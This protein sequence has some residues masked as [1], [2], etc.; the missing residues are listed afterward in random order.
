MMDEWNESLRCPAC[1][2][3]GI[4]RLCQDEDAETPTVR[5]V[6]SGFKIVA[7]EYGPD[8]HCETCNVAV[9]L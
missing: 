5:S 8:F 7:D 1:G 6:P 3:T 9:L 4:A 2:K